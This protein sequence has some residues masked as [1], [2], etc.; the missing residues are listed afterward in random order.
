MF[1]F[2]ILLLHVSSLVGHLQGGNLQRNTF[3]INYV[4]VVHV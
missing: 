2:V 3:K 4:Y 1:I